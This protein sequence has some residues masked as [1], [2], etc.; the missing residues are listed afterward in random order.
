[1]DTTTLNKH[2][3]RMG[4]HRVPD[5]RQEDVGVSLDVL[6]DGGGE[7]FS[8]DIFDKD[9]TADVLQVDKEDKHLLLMVK[10]FNGMSKYLCG[11][12]ERHWFV[13]GVDRFARDI[14][15]AKEGLKSS[16]ALISQRRNKDKTKNKN[17]RKNKGFLRQG[18][19][20]FTPCPDFNEGIANRG[21]I[22]H[23]NE[24]IQRGR[25]KP[26]IVEEIIRS[27]GVTVYIHRDFPDGISQEE[28]QKY[29]KANPNKR[30][31]WQTRIEGARVVGRGKVKHPDHATIT[32]KGWHQISTNRETGLQSVA[33]LD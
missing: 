29:M 32:L 15:D 21:G 13:A 22:I 5:H 16:E 8:I 33:F 26:H 6:R 4:A 25:S 19:W 7:F 1:M 17:K 30:M 12:D 27:G 18:E 24:P 10:D 9:L 28:Y 23:K 3:K 2:F 11:H 31:G 14:A 20:F